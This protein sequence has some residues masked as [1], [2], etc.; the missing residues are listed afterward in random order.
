MRTAS[1][2]VLL[3]GLAQMASAQESKSAT[4]YVEKI[5]CSAC[6]VTVNKALRGVPGVTNVSVDVDKK[7]VTVRFDPTK[8]NATDLTAATA[9]R[10]FPSSIRKLGP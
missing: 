2:A 6:A 7:E 1:L 4:L 8:A 3:L 10:G 5:F 9:K